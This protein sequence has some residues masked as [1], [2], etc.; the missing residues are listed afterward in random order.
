MLRSLPAR[1][2]ESYRR[3]EVREGTGSLVQV[4]WNTYSVD[5]RLIGER[6]EVRVC[7]EYMEVWCGQKRI[8]H[9]PRL[10]GRGKHQINDR[11]II[12]ALVRSDRGSQH[13]YHDF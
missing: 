13:A 7:M 11:H 12:L 9:L 5:S 10:R 4:D 2:R 1:R 6:V 8:E 3:V